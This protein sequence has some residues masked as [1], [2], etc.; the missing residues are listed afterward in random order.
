MYNPLFL[1][2]GFSQ[3]P[4]IEKPFSFRNVN[5]NSSP[6]TFVMWLQLN[7]HKRWMRT[8]FVN[9]R[10]SCFLAAVGWKRWRKFKL[11]L[12]KKNCFIQIHKLS[13][14]PLMKGN[15]FKLDFFGKFQTGMLAI[16]LLC[17][18]FKQRN[19]PVCKFVWQVFN[20]SNC[21][22]RHTGLHFENIR[23]N[24]SR[25]RALQSVQ[26]R[27]KTLSWHRVAKCFKM[28]YIQKALK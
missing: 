15:L 19:P 26:R 21:L 3:R 23:S 7:T 25:S 12:L 17:F 6:F 18:L 24:Q 28:V 14:L 13:S 1:L 5:G 9:L 16:S 2:Y 11:E 4:A 20:K 22:S 27:I 8:E 10:I